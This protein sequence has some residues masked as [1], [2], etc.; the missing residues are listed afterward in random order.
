MILGVILV[1]WLTLMW[2]LSSADGTETLQD[3]MRIAKKLGSLLFDAPTQAQLNRLN[4]ILRKLAHI[5]LYAVLGL[6]V[7]MLWDLLFDRFQIW[8]RAV[9]S[10]VCCTIVAFLDELQKIPIAGRHFSASE[11]I[12]NAVSAWIVISLY[13]LLIWAIH[14]HQSKSKNMHN[15]KTS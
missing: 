13:F 8:L 4:L 5:F 11:S 7:A 6:I 10:F 9:L 14:L 1:G 3:S 15:K 2:R 12:L